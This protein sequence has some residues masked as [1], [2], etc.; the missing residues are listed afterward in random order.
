MTPAT[1]Q[2]GTVTVP[3]AAAA[4][5]DASVTFASGSFSVVRFAHSAGFATPARAGVTAA[6]A[7]GVTAGLKA[8]TTGTN[9]RGTN[10]RGTNE[11]AQAMRAPARI[12]VFMTRMIR[13]K[14]HTV[15]AR[16]RGHSTR[17]IIPFEWRRAG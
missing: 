8:C 7:A 13:E 1:R 10:E 5:A 2:C 15:V 6:S 11:I 12:R 3:V 9:E 17:T 16:L 4:T 14:N